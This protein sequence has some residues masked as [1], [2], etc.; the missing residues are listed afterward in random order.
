MRN[1][2]LFAASSVLLCGCSKPVPVPVAPAAPIAAAVVPT[3]PSK[4]ERK[5]AEFKE[6]VASY[7][8]EGRA[9]SKILSELPTPEK[10]QAASDK[11]DDL[12]THL[13]DP[14]GQLASD[15]ELAKSLK[16]IRAG[17]FVAASLV[18]ADTEIRKLSGKFKEPVEVNKTAAEIRQHCDA[19]EKKL[20]L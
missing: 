2:F 6:Q 8:K 19:I 3:P 18:K 9:A 16:R 10:A 1:L 13:P 7:V 17:A 12:Y 15:E 11:L 20:D 4:E 5:L 14:P